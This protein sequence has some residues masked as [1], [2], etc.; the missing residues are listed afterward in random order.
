MASNNIATIFYINKQHGTRS[1]EFCKRVFTLW[2]WCIAHQIH[3]TSVHVPGVLSTQVNLLSGTQSVEH[4]QSL[5]H[6]HL[7]PDFRTFDHSR[8]NPFAMPDN[9]KRFIFYSWGLLTGRVPGGCF[10]SC[11]RRREPS[12]IC[13]HCFYS[14]LTP[15][16]R[17][18]SMV[19]LASL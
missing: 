15:Y 3:F 14:Y 11:T 18:S 2:H 16:K 12:S 7:N 13:S 10:L 5:N 19:Q 8:V 17:L 6:T 4:E 9:T 1:T